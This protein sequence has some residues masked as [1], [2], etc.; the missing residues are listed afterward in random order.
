MNECIIYI[1]RRTSNN[2]KAGC[3]GSFFVN[4]TSSNRSNKVLPVRSSKA[5]YPSYT[6]SIRIVACV[7]I[8]GIFVLAMRSS[9]SCRCHAEP[10]VVGRTRLA[11]E[12]CNVFI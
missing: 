1:L 4:R 9:S 10:V 12:D 6:Q 7:G 11:G 3:G 8:T 5:E 2:T